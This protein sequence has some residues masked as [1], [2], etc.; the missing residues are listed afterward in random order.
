MQW[1]ELNGLVVGG[2]RYWYEMLNAPFPHQQIAMGVQV[3][4]L[5]KTELV[6]KRHGDGEF[7]SFFFGKQ[8]KKGG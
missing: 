6:S 7:H 3:G 8:K 2:A 1:V 5:I 4:H